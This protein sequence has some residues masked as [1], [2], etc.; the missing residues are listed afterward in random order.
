MQTVQYESARHETPAET[1]S[2][3]RAHAQPFPEAALHDALTWLEWHGDLTPA[4][5]AEAQ[6]FAEEFDLLEQDPEFMEERLTEV[7]ADVAVDKAREA[8]RHRRFTEVEEPARFA[9]VVRLHQSQP[10]PIPEQLH[11]QNRALLAK[12]DQISV[13]RS[14]DSVLS[15]WSRSGPLVHEPTG[16]AELD[17]LTGGGPVYGSRWYLNGQPDAGKTAFL[18]QIAHMFALRGVCVGLLAVDEEDTD[19][20]TRFAQR[21]G[22]TRKNCEIRDPRVIDQIGAE[23][24]DLPVR[25]Y[26]ATWTIEEA[27]TDLAKFANGRRKMLGID[28]LQTVSCDAERAAQRELSEMAGVTAR[29]QAI[30]AVASQHK[31]IALATSEMSRSAY[32][33]ADPSDL[34][35]TMAASKHSGAVEYSARV[36]LGLRSVKDESDLLEVDI[37]KNKHGPSGRQVYLR[38]DRATQTLSDANYEPAPEPE[39]SERRLGKVSKDAERIAQLISETPDMST[40]QLHTKARAVLGLGK[41]AVDA[42]VDSL[43]TKI[44][45]TRGA[46]GAKLMRLC[47]RAG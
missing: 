28:S 6:H 34:T 37:A 29:V 14:I 23:L 26:D 31:L 39:A 36:L 47:D 30:R 17:E 22:H 46:R 9:E 38:V 15:D 18:I 35:S 11:A 1:W 25:F 10:K 5:L 41:D 4:N 8:E 20:V 32:R 27:A 43:G 12:C 7:R 3:A 2:L 44:E 24:A 42:A 33:K 40:R 16:F 19:L 13:G 45:I 21:V